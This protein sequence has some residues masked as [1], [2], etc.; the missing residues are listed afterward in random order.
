MSNI[1]LNFDI[2]EIFP[3]QSSAK[4]EFCFAASDIITDSRFTSPL[5]GF[6]EGIIIKDYQNKMGF[7]PRLDFVDVGGE[8]ID[9]VGKFVDFLQNANRLSIVDRLKIIGSSWARDTAIPDIVVHRDN[10][11]EFYEIKPGS[12]SGIRAGIEKINKFVALCLQYNLPRDRRTY[13][14][15]SGAYLPGTKYKPH[16]Q[17]LAFG[18]LTNIKKFH[19]KVWDVY[20]RVEY[21]R[22]ALLIYKICISGQFIN[23]EEAKKELFKILRK[24]ESPKDK[25]P[26]SESPKDKLPESESPKDKLPKP[27]KTT[28]NPKVK[29]SADTLRREARA[30][31]FKVYPKM[32]GKVIEVHHRIPLEWRRLFP[33]A[34]PNRISNLQGLYTKD[35]LYKASQ[36]WDSFRNT[37]RWLKRSPT[38]SEVVQFAWVVDKSLN[39]PRFLV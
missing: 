19:P 38:P 21:A 5:G 25:L 33:N 14:P 15:Y 17:I 32:K 26:E 13:L 30:I 11:R 1:K 2:K 9:R 3:I 23:Q 4:N 36:L 28:P 16:S 37:Y 34:D 22:P 18:T 8:S 27:I 12:K 7:N 31:F 24:T 39:L 35:H 10:R 20:L 6:I 29:W